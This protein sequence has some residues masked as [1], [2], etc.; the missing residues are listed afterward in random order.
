VT[1]S[2]G[3]GRGLGRFASI[4]ALIVAFFFSSDVHPSVTT[5]RTLDREPPHIFPVAAEPSGPGGLPDRF[6][7]AAPPLRVKPHGPGSGFDPQ[8][9]DPAFV[10]R[11]PAIGLDEVVYQGADQAQ[12]AK[13]PGHYPSCWSGFTPPYCNEF[14]EVWPGESGRVVVG[15]HRTL[16]K[17]DFLRLGELREGHRIYVETRWGNFTYTIIGTSIVVPNDRSVIVP[18]ITERELVLVTCHPKYSAAQRLI[19]FTQLTRATEASSSTGSRR[20]QIPVLR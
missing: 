18:G 7:V 16:E 15:G 2:F 20:T 19:V 3:C 10:L 9:G 1:A 6:L 8:R 12:L 4:C 14:D 13:G 5:A 17:A 11:I